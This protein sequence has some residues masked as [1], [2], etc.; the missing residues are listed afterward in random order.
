MPVPRLRAAPG[1][2]RTRDSAA[3][4]G[5]LHRR[6]ELHQGHQQGRA[7]GDVQDG[8]LHR[9][10]LPRRADIRGR[11]TEPGYDR[12][13]L[14]VDVIANRRHRPGR[15]GRGDAQASHL[16]LR[17]RP[18]IRR[19]G[20]RLRRRLLL[21]A[22]RRVPHVQPRVHRPPAALHRQQRL[23]HVQAVRRHYRRAGAAAVHPARPPGLQDARPAHPSRRGG[24]GGSRSSSGSPPAQ[25]RWARSA[26]RRTRPWPLPPTASAQRAT[27]ARAART[28]AGTRRTPTATPGPA[29]SSR[30]PPAA[31]A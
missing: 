9:S 25:S 31:S 14:H 11:G 15:R 26:G 2:V 30:W 20:D 17:G 13:V 12:P 4:R 5:R 10:E 8:H 24:A 18:R 3:A 22:Q 16:R 28:T 23:P 19:A 1:A 21:A 7:Q 27:R 6:E 29:P